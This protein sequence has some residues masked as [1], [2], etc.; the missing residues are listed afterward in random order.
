MSRCSQ[1]FAVAGRGLQE[2]CEQPKKLWKLN[3]YRARSTQPNYQ[4]AR[5]ALAASSKIEAA[6]AVILIHLTVGSVCHSSS[7]TLRTR[8]FFEAMGEQKYA[9]A[10]CCP[11][12]KDT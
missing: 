12:V 7:W 9:A 4:L 8:P 2:R 11:C 1:I 5:L 6:E 3:T 10:C